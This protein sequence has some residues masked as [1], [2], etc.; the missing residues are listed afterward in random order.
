[1]TGKRATAKRYYEITRENLVKVTL[2]TKAE[3]VEQAVANFNAGLWWTEKTG[4][5]E[6]RLVVADEVREVP[7]DEAGVT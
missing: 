6:E 2:R 3:S 4:L 1:M 7:A 5:V